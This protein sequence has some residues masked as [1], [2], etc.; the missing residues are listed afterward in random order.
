MSK[1][2]VNSN[3]DTDEMIN[4]IMYEK[5]KDDNNENDINKTSG[6]NIQ[7]YGWGNIENLDSQHLN[8]K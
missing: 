8:D 3:L 7:Q 4:N 5:C 2:N 6:D 1:Y